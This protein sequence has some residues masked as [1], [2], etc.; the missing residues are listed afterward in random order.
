M[1]LFLRAYFLVFISLYAGAQ[2]S[3]VYLNAFDALWLD[4]DRNYSYFVAKEIDWPGLRDRYRPEVETVTTDDAFVDVLKRMLTEMKDPHV[5]IK[6][7]G[8]LISTFGLGYTANWNWNVIMG[9]LTEVTQ[10]RDF[11]YTAR[12]KE[13]GFGYFAYIRQGNASD[14]YVDAVIEGIRAL[15]DAPGFILDLRTGASGGDESLARRIASEFCAEPTVYAKSKY[16]DGP[17]HDDFTQDYERVL[18][19]SDEQPYVKPVVCLLGSR[20][21][22]SGEGLAKMLVCL[23]HVT[24]IGTPTRGSSGNPRT[25]E[26]PGLDIGVSYS[27]WVDMMP[28]GTVVEGRG[29]IPDVLDEHPPETFRESDPTWRRA[30]ELLRERITEP[31]AT[32]SAG[33]D[34][35]NDFE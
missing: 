22:S 18:P 3:S 28:A 16:R 30:L 1:S 34:R 9:D 8:D 11:A 20:V 25:F 35:E 23:P 15:K 5:R 4:M 24:S 2:E 33:V 31:V 19:P 21:M 27:R 10:Y 32:S 29:V 14:Q 17:N 13:E 7:G 12:T 26:L 6:V